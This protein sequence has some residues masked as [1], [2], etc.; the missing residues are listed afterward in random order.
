MPLKKQQVLSQFCDKGFNPL[1]FSDHSTCS[2]KVYKYITHKLIDN[3]VQLSKK[4]R[5]YFA[6]RNGHV[7]KM[8]HLDKYIVLDG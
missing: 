1:F 4:S 2:A 7:T 8:I 5:V 6:I 3:V